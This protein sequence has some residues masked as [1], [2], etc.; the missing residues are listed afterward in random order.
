[1]RGE[2]RGVKKGAEGGKAGTDKGWKGM[3]VRIPKAI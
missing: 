2:V 3:K 1:M